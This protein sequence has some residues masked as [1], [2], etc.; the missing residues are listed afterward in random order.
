MATPP[1][2]LGGQEQNQSMDPAAILQQAIKTMQMQQQMSRGG[3]GPISM[4]GQIGMPPQAGP[5]PP[6][7]QVGGG[8]SSVNRGIP[9]ITPNT[10]GSTPSSIPSVQMPNRQAMQ[11]PQSNL[12]TSYRSPEARRGAIA[13]QM[14]NNVL[15]V[16]NQKKQEKF[17]KEKAATANVVNM[18][19]WLLSRG[20]TKAIDALLSDPKNAKLLEKA[21][22]D[23]Y[24]IQQAQQQDTEKAKKTQGKQQSGALAGLQDAIGQN[25]GQA[26]GMPAGGPQQGGMTNRV[27]QGIPSQGGAPGAQPGQSRTLQIEPTTQEKLGA[28]TDNAKLQALQNDPDLLRQAALGTSLSGSELKQAEEIA[29]NLKVSP[30]QLETWNRQADIEDKRIAADLAKTVASWEVELKTTAAKLQ[31]DYKL[32]QQ[33]MA[34]KQKLAQIQNG[35][36]Y[37]RIKNAQAMH[38]DVMSWK[39]A[40]L[41][42]NTEKA[43]QFGAQVYDKLGEDLEKA[44]G[45]IDDETKRKE[46]ISQAGAYHKK[47]DELRGSMINLDELLRDR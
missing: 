25:A 22:L 20:D 10:S 14:L 34:N 3:R 35:P 42:G 17:E 24:K 31:Q 26:A 38:D 8:P 37:A 15:G 32:A 47:A 6:F 5:T 39:K 12:D 27:P 11:L 18:Y 41:D 30:T 21:G 44:A 1:F 29:T 43:K 19:L 33:D 23:L 4:P 40:V 9:G 45:K 2:V 36:E 16:V 7:T 13:Q 28:L 46:M